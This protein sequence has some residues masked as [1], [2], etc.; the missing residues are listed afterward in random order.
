MGADRNPKV[1]V[2]DESKDKSFSEHNALEYADELDTLASIVKETH[3]LPA[4]LCEQQL[5]DLA[6]AELDQTI[7]P[8]A[9]INAISGKIKTWMADT[10]ASVDVIDESHLSNK[11]WNKL[12][13]L[14]QPLTYGT[15]A[16][17]VTVDSTIA[18]HS[19]SIGDIDA[20]ILKDSPS[21]ISVGRRCMEQGFGFYWHPY[22]EPVIV[23]PDTKTIIKCAVQDYVPYVVEADGVVCPLAAEQP[24]ISTSS[25]SRDPPRDESHL[26][27]AKNSPALANGS[28][29][30][31]GHE[32]QPQTENKVTRVNKMTDLFSKLRL[33]LI[34]ISL[35]T[36][37]N[38]LIANR[39]SELKCKGSLIE[40]KRFHSLNALRLKI[41]VIW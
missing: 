20:V 37:L 3:D 12:T 6:K 27:S 24:T 40:R 13:R 5:G 9:R 11:G 25:S 17:D 33:L 8:G 19:K 2:G 26:Q 35:L 31:P 32:E 34:T 39:A 41:L 15:A 14:D 36:L 30:E 1:T 22:K 10:G 29:I 21:V 7:A 18:L 28:I 38:T 23:H 16:G 4:H